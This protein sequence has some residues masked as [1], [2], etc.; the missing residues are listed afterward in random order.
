MKKV[1]PLLTFDSTGSW[2]ACQ[3]VASCHSEKRSSKCRH[4]YNSGSV[5]INDPGSVQNRKSRR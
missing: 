1:Y 3:F 2:D 4:N 5:E